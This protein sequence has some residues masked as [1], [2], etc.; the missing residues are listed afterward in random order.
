MLLAITMGFTISIHQKPT[1]APEPKPINLDKIN[2]KLD[3]ILEEGRARDT[4]LL[5][6]L[7]KLQQQNQGNQ[8]R[9]AEVFIN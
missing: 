9:V 3:L 6:Q 5:Q 7:L 1:R 2:A 4:V 8:G